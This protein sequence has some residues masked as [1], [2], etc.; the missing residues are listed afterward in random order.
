MNDGA[1]VGASVPEVSVVVVTWNSAPVIGGCLESL[2]QALESLDAEVIV[3]DNDS[4]DS[5]LAVV[6]H[7]MPSAR[8]IANPTN[9]GLAAANNQGMKAARGRRYLIANPDVVFDP[10]AVL[11]M[12]DVMD[13]HERA[14]WVVSKVLYEDGTLQTSVGNLPTLAEAVLGRQAAR[15]RAPGSP[16]GFWWDG[17]PHDEE[18]TVGRTFE[19]AYLI[20]AAAVDV[21]GLQDERYVLDWEG[22]DW[23]ER[24]S[25]AGWEIWLAPKAEVVHLGGTS[26]RQVPFRSIVSQ[27]RGMYMYYSDRRRTLWKPILY[28]LFWSR[29]LGKLAITRLGVPLYSWGHR[30]RKDAAA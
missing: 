1:D 8:I 4:A 30:D 27:H 15:R 11:A 19:C 9:R 20:R 23:V 7:T 5:T 17:W 29:A 18:R 2:G 10:G 21:V 14:G 22:Q 24:F 25:R 13:R 26:R 28:A 12:V 16:T 3:I 6:S